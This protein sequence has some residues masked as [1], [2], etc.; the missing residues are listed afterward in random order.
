VFE[1]SALRS[2]LPMYRDKDKEGCERKIGGIVKGKGRGDIRSSLSTTDPIWTAVISVW[3]LRGYRSVISCKRL[4]HIYPKRHKFM[5]NFVHA[6][7]GS[8]VL[9]R[10][11]SYL[12][13]YSFITGGC[14][15]LVNCKKLRIVRYCSNVI[16][17][18]DT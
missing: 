5:Q 1:S 14:S 2:P 10:S 15:K 18:S 7:Y 8:K 9:R 16:L 4:C 13:T 6:I 11:K 12:N 17:T 3:R